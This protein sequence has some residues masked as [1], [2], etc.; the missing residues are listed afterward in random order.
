MAFF[1]FSSNN[2]NYK[3]RRKTLNHLNFAKVMLNFNLESLSKYVAS[4]LAGQF[5]TKT[6]RVL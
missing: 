6:D 1:R 4:I 5:N 3:Q 2:T